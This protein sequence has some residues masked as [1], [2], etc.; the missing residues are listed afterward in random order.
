MM[1]ETEQAKGLPAGWLVV[2]A[3]CGVAA[4]MLVWRRMKK[5]P[6]VWDVDSV[7]GACDKAAAKLEGLLSQ[8]TCVQQPG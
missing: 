3:L 4:T 1:E 8:E 2:G 5:G 6:Q 7:L